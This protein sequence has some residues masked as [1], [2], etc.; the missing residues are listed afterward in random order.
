MAP[1][2]KNLELQPLKRIRLWY[3]FIT[4]IIAIFCLRLFYL[5]VIRYDHY[6][7]AALSDQLKQYELP[8]TRGAI[9]AYDGEDSVPIVLNQTLYVIYADP[10][11]IKKA[12][13]VAS[14]LSDTLGGS[15]SDYK[16]KI[17]RKGKRYVVLAKKV[18]KATKE[19]LL[20]HEFAGIGAQ[21]QSYRVYPQGSLAAQVL[22]FVN[23]EGTGTY[24]IEQALNSKL[25]GT[26]GRLKA[27]TDVHGVPLASS[28]H[29]VSVPPKAGQ[30]VQ[31]TIDLGMQKQMENILKR[32]YKQTKSQGLSAVI[33]DPSNGQ[34]KAMAN[35]PSYNPAEYSKVKNPAVFQN[36]VVSHTIEP[37]SVMKSL[38]AAAA[39]DSGAVQPNSTFYD[40]AHWLIDGYNI[41]DVEIDGGAR[42][43]SVQS[44]LT[45]S[46]NT[47]ATWLLMR[48]GGS[49]DTVKQ[50]GI[51]V[52]HDYMVNHY[53][54]GRKTNI[55]Q[56]YDPAGYIPSYDK[57]QPALGLKFANTAF[58]QAVLITPLQM[59]AAYASAL[60]GG[61]YYQPQLISQITSPDGV[62]SKRAPKILKKNVVKP[63]VSKILTPMLEKVARNYS[64]VS[65]PN[66]QF[67]KKYLI[68]GKTGTAQIA[69]PGGGYHE[70]LD[71]GTYGGFVGGKADKPQ[72][73]I[74]VYNIRPNVPGFAGSRGAMPIFADLAHMM[75]DNGYAVPK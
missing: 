21:A 29:N 34:I 75:I 64:P 50:K 70:K 45:L 49:N 72:Y 3:A 5:Q 28:Q 48:M 41:T 2:N 47:G 60:N 57:S 43:Q 61:T 67:P 62:V 36:G 42:E 52:W 26:P 17:T 53:L 22:G 23:D 59:A 4:I 10:V 15:A 11:Y 9:T 35:Y 30:Q 68:G 44:T 12:D 31:L 39:L 14:T 71:N 58:G 56:G 66:M 19:T 7:T 63:S 24:G 8:A 74:V 16:E 55:E 65:F 51:E 38:T 6:K 40:P 46:L 1:Q 69:S 27:I 37:G 73:I 18:S 25:K 13:Q 33:L 54:F 32:E 20:K